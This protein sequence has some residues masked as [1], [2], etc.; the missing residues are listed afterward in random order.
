MRAAYPLSFQLYSAREFPPVEEQ[1]PVLARLG[2]KNVE[3]FAALYEAPE[4]FRSLLDENGL[5]ALSGHFDLAMLEA[6]AGRAVDIARV[7]GIEIIVAPWL[8]PEDRPADAEGWKAIGRRLAMLD[9]RLSA[10]GLAFAWHTHDFEFLALPDGTFPIEHLLEGNTVGLELDVAWV[11]RA[12]GNPVAWLKKYADRIV[13][14][15]VKDVAGEGQNGEQDGW[16]DLG[17]GTIDWTSIWPAVTATRARLAILEHDKPVD[18]HRF[19]QRSAV[20]FKAL[21]SV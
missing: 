3:P 9:E 1:L 5:T 13:A 6:E 12:G 2:Y 8:N 16:A 18:W 4:R 19:A 10:A 7:L 20:E 17:Y 14:V 15:H 11:V 21:R